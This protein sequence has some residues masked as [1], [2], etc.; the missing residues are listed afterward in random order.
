MAGF[1]FGPSQF[2]NPLYLAGYDPSQ[3]PFTAPCDTGTGCVLPHLGKTRDI[4]SVVP[5]TNGISFA[6]QAVIMLVIGA[7]AD[8][9]QWRPYITIIFTLLA[10]AVSLAWLGVEDPSKWQ[11]G[12]ILYVLGY[13][14]VVFGSP[15]SFI[16]SNAL[17]Q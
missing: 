2:Q 15:L 4:N 5:L 7:W 11:I 1:N 12:V 17:C 3:P 13:Q 8:Y 9:G 16:R 6:I 10:V 14:S